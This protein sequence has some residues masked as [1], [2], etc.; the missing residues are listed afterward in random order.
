MNA[1]N[2]AQSTF[3]AQQ[4]TVVTQTG[5]NGTSLNKNSAGANLVWNAYAYSNQGF[6]YGAFASSR[7]SQTNNFVMFGLSTNQ[8]CPAGNLSATNAYAAISYAWYFRGDGILE[9]YESGT[10]VTTYGTYNTS[11]VA[12]ITYDGTNIIYWKDGV[13]QRTVARSVGAPLYFGYAPYNNGGS[14]INSVQFDAFGSTTY[15]GRN[16]IGTI[17]TFT[18]NVCIGTAVNQNCLLGFNASA[19]INKVI[20]L[21]SFSTGDPATATDFNG[22]GATTTV[23]RYQSTTSGGGG[24]QWYCGATEAMR[25]GV[26]AGRLCLGIG[27]SPSENLDVAGDTT[28]SGVMKN[29]GRPMSMVGKNNGGVTSGIMVFNSVAYNI[30]SMYNSTNGRWTASVAGYYQFTYC[31]ISRFTSNN[32]NNRWNKNGSDFGWGATHSN[33]TNITAPY[34]MQMS[35]AVIIFLA[36]NDYIEFNVL[37]DGFYGDSTIHNTACCIFLG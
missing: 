1:L 6:K 20:S 28:V 7:A 31:G 27:T 13:S 17:G 18:G 16:I 29:P 21:Y 37:S 23:L 33:F 34:H 8:A 9:I 25:I 24:H 26:N 36:V 32:P 11:T 10:S 2:Y 12:S 5:A 15:A 30:G 19:G 3:T 35:C 4:F 22:F 14:T